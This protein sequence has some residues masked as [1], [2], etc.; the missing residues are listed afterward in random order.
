MLEIV[1]KMVF[2]DGLAD[3]LGHFFDVVVVGILFGV[4]VFHFLFVSWV[5]GQYT[6][7]ILEYHVG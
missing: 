5:R 7:D 3:L 2:E 4:V 6:W 1:Q